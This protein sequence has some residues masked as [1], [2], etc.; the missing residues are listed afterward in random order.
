M[1]S[2]S[3]RPAGDELVNDASNDVGLTKEE[4]PSRFLLPARRL[5]DVS[6]N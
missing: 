2:N 4:L 1:S 6:A 3:A 5:F